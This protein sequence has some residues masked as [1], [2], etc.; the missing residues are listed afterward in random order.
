MRVLVAD[1]N[2]ALI[3]KLVR[4]LT[5]HNYVVDVANDG[6]TAYTWATHLP[7][8]VILL[9]LDLPE[10]DG[11]S[12]CRKLRQN[13][14]PSPI[15]ILSALGG[16]KDKVKGLDAGADDFVIEPIDLEEIA[17]RIRALLR[18]AKVL[19]PLVL[20]YQNLLLNPATCEVRYEDS[21]LNLTAIEFRL[22]QLFLKNRDRVFSNTTILSQLWNEADAPQE[23]TVRAHIKRLRK[24]LDEAGA[25]KHLIETVYGLGYRLQKKS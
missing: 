6:K 2:Q 23:D 25:P 8:D 16:V 14:I 19:A 24:K 15:L 20:E 9:N 18:R 1:T 3:E 4:Y 13:D 11:F 7:Y 21:F 5:R 12:F 17:A 10:L 22:L